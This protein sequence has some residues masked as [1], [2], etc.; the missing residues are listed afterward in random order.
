MINNIALV[1]LLHPLDTLKTRFQ[2][3]SFSFPGSYYTSLVQASYVIT[4]QEGIL[5]LYKGMGPALVGSMISWSLYF[6]SYHFFK[7]R[8]V[9]WGETVPTHLTA[10]SCAGI[11]TCLVTNPLWLVYCIWWLCLKVA[12]YLGLSKR[13]YSYN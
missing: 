8:L 13:G 5:A 1:L 9:S 10:S 12:W 11:V 2:A 3:K 6:Q 4:K 7:S